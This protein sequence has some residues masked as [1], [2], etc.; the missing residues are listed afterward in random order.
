MTTIAAFISLC[1]ARHNAPFSIGAAGTTGMAV[2][3]FFTMVMIP[4]LCE[5]WLWDEG[6]KP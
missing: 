1:F 4:F 3:L 6:I 5:H 2:T